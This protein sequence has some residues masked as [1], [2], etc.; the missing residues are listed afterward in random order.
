M[1][2]KILTLPEL[3]VASRDVDGSRVDE[4]NLL[5]SRPVT[6]PTQWEI[7]VFHVGTAGGM[8]FELTATAGESTSWNISLVGWGGSH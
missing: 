3:Q 6:D 4:A 8:R 5:R 7:P 1:T 2:C